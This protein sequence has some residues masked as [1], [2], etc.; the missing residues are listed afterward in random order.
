[1]SF[2]RRYNGLAIR[3]TLPI[4]LAPAGVPPAIRAGPST[5]PA[6]APLPA[7]YVPNIPIF[8]IGP[9]VGPM[10]FLSPKPITPMVPIVAQAVPPAPAAIPAAPKPTGQIMFPRS[11][12][13]AKAEAD[14]AAADAAR[15]KAAADEAEAEA[16][17]SKRYYET[18][19]GGGGGGGGGAVPDY[20]WDQEPEVEE[21]PVTLPDGTPGTM[22]VPS[23]KKHPVIYSA[24]AAG[25]GFLLGGPVGAL[26]GAAAGYLF[27]K[28]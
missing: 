6:Q 26:V 15:I 10:N 22:L 17:R 13:R 27:S 8:P 21:V 7:V 25:A 5:L 19:G 2:Y 16:K 18:Q 1:M 24:G 28:R 3:S 12:V 11:Q 9:Q 4:S 20:A 14:A 23:K